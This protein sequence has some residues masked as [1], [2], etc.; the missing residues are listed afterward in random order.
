MLFSQLITE[1]EKGNS[2]LQ[3]HN[4]GQDPNIISGASL[5]KAREKKQKGQEATARQLFK[6]GK[7]K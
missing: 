3:G 1:L 5:D 6:G 7:K 4:I 2:K